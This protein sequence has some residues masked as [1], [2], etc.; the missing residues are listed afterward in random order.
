MY[1]YIYRLL[2]I[3]FKKA[4]QG[5]QWHSWLLMHAMARRCLEQFAPIL[6]WPNLLPYS[7]RSQHKFSSI[8]SI[9][10]HVHVHVHNIMYVTP[11]MESS[12]KHTLEWDSKST[13]KKKVHIIITPLQIWTL[14]IKLQCS[15]Y[16]CRWCWPVCKR[17]WKA[18]SIIHV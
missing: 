2:E 16:V 4:H 15:V 3:F 7:K 10:V 9:H 1:I 13:L 11:V 17:D 14:Q 18:G 12:E 6:Q 8:S 5:A